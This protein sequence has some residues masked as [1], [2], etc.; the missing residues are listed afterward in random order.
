MDISVL[1]KVLGHRDLAT[2]AIYLDLVGD[3]IMNEFQKVE[4]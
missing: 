2:T 3:D 4:W 1:Q